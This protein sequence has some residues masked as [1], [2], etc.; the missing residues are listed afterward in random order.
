[1]RRGD[2]VRLAIALALGVLFFAGLWFYV[3]SSVESEGRRHL[4]G[5]VCGLAFGGLIVDTVLPCQCQRR[6]APPAADAVDGITVGTPVPDQ[7]DVDAIQILRDENAT[8]TARLQQLEDQEARAAETYKK[9]TAL[10]KSAHLDLMGMPP[11]PG[12][13][14]PALEPF[15]VGHGLASPQAAVDDSSAN[16]GLGALHSWAMGQPPAGPVS[17][18]GMTSPQLRREYTSGQPAASAPPGI[19][20][21]P[22]AGY[23]GPS[24]GASTHP[25]YAPFSTGA[26]SVNVCA[27]AVKEAA[28]ACATERDATGDPAWNRKFWAYVADQDSRGLMDAKVLLVLRSFG[29]VGGASVSH[30]P[31]KELSEALDRVPSGLAPPLP[32]GAVPGISLPSALGPG[33]N[34][35]PT[36]GMGGAV[37]QK[38]SQGLAPHIRRAAPETY[39]NIRACGANTTREWLLT[40]YVGSRQTSQWQDLWAMCTNIDF[41]LEKC[42][43][44]DEVIQRLAVDD[45]LE[46]ALRHVSAYIY[47][48]RTKDHHG[49]ARMRAVVAPGAQTDVAPEWLVND[50]TQS[51]K[52]EHQRNDRVNAEARR[53]KPPKG[54]GKGKEDQKDA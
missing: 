40:A 12:L 18:F 23:F 8:L 52:V 50:V 9:K 13:A 37:T 21:L 39:R 48:S 35:A 38:W 14:A 45:Q 6:A 1:M 42:T 30:F 31:V 27:K 19:P 46:V 53:R 20:P 5:C 49:A 29:Y 41:A 32:G 15:G 51:S 34:L 7:G 4:A 16:D 36:S 44:E 10:G 26:G 25:T 47:E 11:P 22:T 24:A 43:T 33:G 54:R 3:N 2:S 28:V 17:T